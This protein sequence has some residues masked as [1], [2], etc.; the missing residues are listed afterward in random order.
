MFLL[1]KDEL[2]RTVLSDP[3]ISIYACGRQDIA[4]GAI[5]KRVLAVLEFLSR[6]GLKPTVTALRCGHSETTVSGFVSE[7]YTG[8]AVD[9]SAINGTPIAGHQGAGSITDLTIR[10]LLTLQGE[11]VPHQIISLMQYP[12]APNTLAMPEHW[13]HIHIGFRPVAG[14]VALSPADAAKA[15]HSASTG[16]TAPVPVVT[17]DPLN[18]L[19]WNQLVTRIGA[20]PA[21]KVAAKPSSAAVKDP[22]PPTK[23]GA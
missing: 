16:K 12:G 10:A 21:P 8:D 22:A 6:I 14:D 7:H 19:Q 3:G 20:L 2:E 13:N 17:P 4:S 18:S 1:S 15:A 23:P 11:F 5:D 9:I